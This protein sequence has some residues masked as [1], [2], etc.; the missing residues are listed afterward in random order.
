MAALT[1][2]FAL[3]IAFMLWVY[4]SGIVL[5]VGAVITSLHEQRRRM[6][7]RAERAAPFAGSNKLD[8]AARERPDDGKKDPG[9]AQRPSDDGKALQQQAPRQQPL[10]NVGSS[11]GDAAPDEASSPPASSPEPPPPDRSS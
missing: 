2:S 11:D 1:G 9:S 5:M 10:R 6:R 4:W 3:L 7:R 8:A